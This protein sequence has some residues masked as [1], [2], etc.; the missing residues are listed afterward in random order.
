VGEIDA[1]SGPQGDGLGGHGQE[2]VGLVL[3]PQTTTGA[4]QQGSEPSPPETLEGPGIGVLLQQ[5]Q[6]RLGIAA[7]AQR[8]GPTRSEQFDQG[9][10][11]ETGGS[12]P[13]DHAGPLAGGSAQRLCRT[14]VVD[15]AQPFGVE[16]GQT[17]QHPRVEPVGLGVLVVI[18]T[19]I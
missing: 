6:G 7:R 5:D 16:H 3:T 1:T 2:L 11:A 13:L 10:E 12:A 17:S 4:H 19:Q 18:V 8:V 9:V 14:Q 15:A